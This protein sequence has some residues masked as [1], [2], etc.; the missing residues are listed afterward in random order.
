M[1]TRPKPKPRSKQQKNVTTNAAA[2]AANDAKK[3]IVKS[4][5]ED[6]E[7]CNHPKSKHKDILANSMKRCEVK[8]CDCVGA[9]EW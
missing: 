7:T 2:R 5:I 3:V 6:C 4:N 1:S 9:K 8:P